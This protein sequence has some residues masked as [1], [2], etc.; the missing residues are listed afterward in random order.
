[1]PRRNAR[2]RSTRAASWAIRSAMRSGRCS[3]IR[4]S[5]SPASSAMAKRKPARW[6]RRGIPTSFSIRSPTGRCCRFCISTATRLPTRPSSPA[7]PARSWN[8]CSA[9]TAG[10]PIFVEGHE[11]ELM[12]EAMAATLDTAVEQIK[13]D[14]A[15]RPRPRQ[16][17]ASA[18]ADDRPQFAQG[19]DWTESGRWPA[20]RR[21]VSRASGAARRIF[22]DASRASPAA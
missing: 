16:H 11:P 13:T 3:T 17:R 12:H 14:P 4:I 5:S 6:P 9:A 22:H 1:M 20:S 19:L 2:A 21:H 15:R 8:S 18:L 10:R 7:S